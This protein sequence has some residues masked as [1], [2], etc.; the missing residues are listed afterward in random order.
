MLL[1]SAFVLL[2][3]AHLHAHQPIMEVASDTPHHSL[4]PSAAA[5][6]AA[7]I[8]TVASP[9]LTITKLPPP[10]S[11]TPLYHAAVPTT[12]TPVSS[13]SVLKSPQAFSSTVAGMEY[14]HLSSPSSRAFHQHQHQ[15]T[16]SLSSAYCPS[17]A[18]PLSLPPSHYHYYDSA[19][20]ADESV[21]SSVDDYA[22]L[23]T[24]QSTTSDELV[25]HFDQQDD[26]P[27]GHDKYEM[28]A[29]DCSR[30]LS[31]TPG[32][33]PVAAPL[34]IEYEDAYGSESSIASS[35][36]TASPVYPSSSLPPLS[37]SLAGQ[38]SSASSV[39]T[40]LSTHAQSHVQSNPPSPHDEQSPAPP[41]THASTHALQPHNDV[42]MTAYTPHPSAS[43]IFYEPHTSPQPLSQ[44]RH[45]LLPPAMPATT[46]LSPPAALS[47]LSHAH[48][49]VVPLTPSDSVCSAPFL[50]PVTGSPFPFSPP[51][52]LG[53][54]AN[55]GSGMAAADYVAAS[56]NK[57]KAA[58]ATM[59][60]TRPTD[61]HSWAM[62]SKIELPATKKA[63]SKAA[64]AKKNAAIKKDKKRK[65]DESDDSDSDNDT[66]SS[67]SSSS[68][69]SDSDD[70]SSF[71]ASS[72]RRRTHTTSS[73]STTTRRKP[74]SK[75]ERNKMSASAYRKRKK[76]HI[77]ALHGVADTLKTTVTQQSDMIDSITNE[78]KA[79]REQ[80]SF[81]QKLFGTSSAFL[82]PQK[83]K[84]K[85][86]AVEE[87]EKVGAPLPIALSA[88]PKIAAVVPPP[89]S[90]ALIATVIVSGQVTVLSPEAEKLD[91][92]APLLKPAQ[93]ETEVTVKKESDG[94]PLHT[95]QDAATATTAVATT[96]STVSSA[97]RA[98]IFLFVIFTCFL[99]F[100]PNSLHAPLSD[101]AFNQLT[102]SFLNHQYNGDIDIPFATFTSAT[103]HSTSPASP[104][105]F[106]SSFYPASAASLLS[107]ESVVRQFMDGGLGDES[108]FAELLDRTY[109]PLVRLVGEEAAQSAIMRLAGGMLTLQLKRQQPAVVA[110]E[111][112]G[113][114]GGGLVDVVKVKTETE[115][116]LVTDSSSAVVPMVDVPIATQ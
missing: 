41:S 29:A 115:V 7:Q 13:T 59:V 25:S 94:K 114:G 98:S 70:D 100:N 60:Q 44:P 6:D 30:L 40:E 67:D 15:L 99:L 76:A 9:N 61:R 49:P 92:S 39:H 95:E 97:Q 3:H 12:T 21:V 112:G 32:L 14:Y 38:L 106:L 110:M 105:S 79:L 71:S 102:A 96:L 36:A 48:F 23:S 51:V 75:K 57:L 65:R 89:N 82:M 108:F 47:L 27:A 8:T 68:S 88:S 81:I 85:G 10:S 72:T 54:T 52:P 26:K 37:P 5:H 109:V 53:Q 104:L 116:D 83:E 2:T 58:A 93:P 69:D 77:V 22:L 18:P 91:L 78:N 103:Q 50:P 56:Y 11:S 20:Y 111:G 90:V 80:L 73:S 28:E 19:S 35:S 64:K 86:K 66:D 55:G 87:K 45:L 4:P 63:A 43:S 24:V 17:S 113:D 107:P 31:F 74:L 1:A 62:G 42:N 46:A 34:H 84:E 101:L 33:Q 16:P